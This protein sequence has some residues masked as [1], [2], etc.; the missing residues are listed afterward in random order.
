MAYRN[1]DLFSN[2]VELD[3]HAMNNII[4]DG[5]VVG[6]DSLEYITAFMSS[7]KDKTS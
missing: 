2:L 6:E 4:S 3:L 5:G 7:K 1:T